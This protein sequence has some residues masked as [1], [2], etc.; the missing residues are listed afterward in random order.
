MY[1]LL[2]YY[3]KIKLQHNLYMKDL[4]DFFINFFQGEINHAIEAVTNIK[5]PFYTWVFLWIFV[6][7]Y[8]KF[9]GF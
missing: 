3:S 8:R 2:L 9:N 5:S 7:I 4:L 1:I 6:R